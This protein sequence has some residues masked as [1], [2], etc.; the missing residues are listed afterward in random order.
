[1][2][3]S[4][5]LS[6]LGVTAVHPKDGSLIAPISLLSREGLHWILDGT[7]DIPSIAHP[8]DRSQVE[9]HMSMARLGNNAPELEFR[10]VLPDGTASWVLL[11]LQPLDATLDSGS[12][13]LAV[14]WAGARGLLQIMPDTGSVLARDAG[15]ERFD[16]DDLFVPRINIRLGSLYLD[17]LT[18]RFDG[19]ASAAIASY[20]AGPEAT[21]RW[22]VESPDVEDDVWVESIP[23]RQ[24]REYV[25]R[26]LRSVHAY[27]ELY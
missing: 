22:L 15:L 11:T 6:E 5:L 26:V 27:R 14:S 20:N 7:V 13:V 17:Q 12:T 2:V 10:V 18:R 25:K 21:A 3:L 16:P 4:W 23:Y 19:N 24:T 1:M 9:K 8:D